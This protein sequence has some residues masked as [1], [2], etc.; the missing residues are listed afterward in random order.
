MFLSKGYEQNRARIGVW[1]LPVVVLGC[2][3]EDC[4]DECARYFTHVLHTDVLLCCSYD[5]SI[6]TLKSSRNQIFQRTKFLY[7]LSPIIGKHDDTQISVNT[8]AKLSQELSMLQ[9]PTEKL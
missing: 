7:L 2:E 4:G 3:W 6:V 5:P 1:E 8:L 9:C